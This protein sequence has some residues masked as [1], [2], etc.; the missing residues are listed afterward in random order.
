V[1]RDGPIQ[2]AWPL[3]FSF[4]L[5]CLFFFSL[6][7]WPP[8][9]TTPSC[10]HH[11]YLLPPSVS[12]L[13]LPIW[14]YMGRFVGSFGWLKPPTDSLSFVGMPWPFQWTSRPSPA[15]DVR[16]ASG[17]GSYSRPSFFRLPYFWG[18]LF[19]TLHLEEP[20]TTPESNGKFDLT[21]Q[22]FAWLGVRFQTFCCSRH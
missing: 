9:R 16:W 2:V 19:K 20:I 6:F 8:D 14:S 15:V 4:R 17:L 22:W 21:L 11:P 5:P 1:S 10:H 12:P 13:Y 3:S 7:F 18:R